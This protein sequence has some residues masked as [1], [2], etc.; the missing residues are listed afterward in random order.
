MKIFLIEKEHYNVRHKIIIEKE[1]Y[2]VR[3]KTN[4]EKKKTFKKRRN[5]K[6]N[7]V[8]VIEKRTNYKRKKEKQIWSQ[9]KKNTKG[10]IF[11]KKKKETK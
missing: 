6:A 11:T 10:K 7:N 1:R 4:A 2:N 5:E 3:H 8:R 9:I